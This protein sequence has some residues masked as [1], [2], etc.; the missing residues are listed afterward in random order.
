MLI[1]HLETEDDGEVAEAK[2]DLRMPEIEIYAIQVS[3][4][5]LLLRYAQFNLLAIYRLRLYF[6]NCDVVSSI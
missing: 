3:G 1:K 6:R 4:T 2:T 5:K